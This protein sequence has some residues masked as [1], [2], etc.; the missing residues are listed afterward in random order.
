MGIRGVGILQG[1]GKVPILDARADYVVVH[2]ILLVCSMPLTGERGPC[3]PSHPALL[4]QAPRCPELMP[5]HRLE[6]MA[7]LQPIH[8]LYLVVRNTLVDLLTSCWQAAEVCGVGALNQVGVEVGLE[9]VVLDALM[10][11][12][13]VCGR[14]QL[15]LLH[16]E[17]PQMILKHQRVVA[18]VQAHLVLL[19][20]VHLLLW[21]D[22][23]PEV[24]VHSVVLGL[25]EAAVVEIGGVGV[26]ALPPH[27][28]LEVAVASVA[29]VAGVLDLV[30]HQAVG[31]EDLR[32]RVGSVVGL[33]LV[34]VLGV[35]LGL[36]H[37]SG[38]RLAILMA[39]GP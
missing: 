11:A 23:A 13:Q 5:V 33:P 37:A 22:V 27:L 7:V 4:L 29:R 39:V 9:I 32:V 38:L 31:G 10:L 26:V 25:D 19:L 28:E 14:L 1:I 16:P 6:E 2:P 34:L 35:R 18:V 12:P 3:S 24:R 8:L 20:V 30:R 36:V 21:V 17:A 15:V